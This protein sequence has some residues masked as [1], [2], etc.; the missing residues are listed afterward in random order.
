M[1]LYITPHDEQIDSMQ[2]WL[3]VSGDL[4]IQEMIK[5]QDSASGTTSVL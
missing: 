5:D 4:E 1:S 2:I 3:T